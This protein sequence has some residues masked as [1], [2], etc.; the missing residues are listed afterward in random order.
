MILRTITI[1]GV[2]LI[3]LLVGSCGSNPPMSQQTSN[4]VQT[5]PH[6]EP[7]QTTRLPS[8]ANPTGIQ[9][10]PQAAQSEYHIVPS[11]KERIAT[12]KIIVI[13]ELIDQGEVI[14]AARDTSDRTQ[15]AANLFGVGQVYHVRV[16]RY[17]KGTGPNTLNIGSL[18]LPVNVPISRGCGLGRIGAE[19]PTATD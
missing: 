1:A 9:P 4:T 8:A 7:T 15:P 2:V 18:G 13:G 6:Q 10:Q 12:S 11:L 5:S 14:N 3:C 16:A 19:S 17:L